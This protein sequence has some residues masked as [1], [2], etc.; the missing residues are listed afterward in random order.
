MDIRPAHVRDAAR[1]ESIYRHYAL[2][3]VLTADVDD[4]PTAREWEL[5]LEQLA[6]SGYPTLVAAADRD[7]VGYALL[8]PWLA[9]PA[10]AHTA[11]NSIYLDPNAVGAG[12][13]RQLL[14]RLLDDARACG[15]REVIALVADGEHEGRASRALHLGAGYRH[16]GR[17]QRVG[18]KRGRITDVEL[19]Q[20]SL[21]PSD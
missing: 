1:I 8:M 19:L 13:G 15:I 17:L 3:S 4:S 2:H 6:A 20:R 5:R 10:F 21:Q 11:E 14:D 18:S 12:I 16:V 9:K 7:V